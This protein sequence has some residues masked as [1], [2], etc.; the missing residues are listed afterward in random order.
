MQSKQGHLNSKSSIEVDEKKSTL[1]QDI[2]GFDKKDSI[3]LEQSEQKVGS[4]G[5]LNQSMQNTTNYH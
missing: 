3:K 1:Q 4:L 5:D 2:K